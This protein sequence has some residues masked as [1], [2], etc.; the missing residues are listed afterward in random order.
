MSD[1]KVGDRVIDTDPELALMRSIM[2]VSGNDASNT[3]TVTEISDDTAF[4]EYE[5]GGFAPCL[6]T[7]LVKADLNE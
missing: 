4:V 6:L 3:G 2:G 1:I 7:Q 5:D